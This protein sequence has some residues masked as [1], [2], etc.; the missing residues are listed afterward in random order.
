MKMKKLTDWSQVPA[1]SKFKVI[2]NSNSHNYPMG[3]VLT[4]KFTTS[5]KGANNI[6]DEFTSGNTLDVTDIIML[7][8]TLEGMKIE[9]IELMERLDHLNDRIEFCT[10]N[11]LEEFDEQSYKVVMA[12][13][14][15]ESS[16]TRK[17]K[18]E[19]LLKLLQ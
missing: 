15:L 9:R 18:A 10:D 4:T 8:S 12:L 5:G 6:A 13:D 16:K 17:E 7:S 14:T 2:S 1:K 3:V 19:M 11:H